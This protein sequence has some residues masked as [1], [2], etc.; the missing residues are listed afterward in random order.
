MTIAKLAY[1]EIKSLSSDIVDRWRLGAETPFDFLLPLL[2]YPVWVLGM[3]TLEASQ[4]ADSLEAV[5]GT[6]VTLKIATLNRGRF[7]ISDRDKLIRTVGGAIAHE[8]THVEQKKTYPE[9]FDIQSAEQKRWIAELGT[10]FNTDTWSLSEAEWASGYYYGFEIEAHAAQIALE[11]LHPNASD[12]GVAEAKVRARLGAKFEPILE[13]P[14][15]T[16][17]QTWR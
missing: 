13:G 2:G 9:P 10:R 12:M 1:S 3:P 5:G 15:A 7:N 6:Y 8:A 14:I 4:A 17:Q 16:I 11:R